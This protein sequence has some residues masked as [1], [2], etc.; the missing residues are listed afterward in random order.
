ML[1]AE[2]LAFRKRGIGGSESAAILGVHPWLSAIEL[3]AQKCGFSDSSDD[4]VRLRCGS[5][6]ESFVRKEYER[7][8]GNAVFYSKARCECLTH[9][10]I[11]EMLANVDGF[12]RL[13]GHDRIVEIKTVSGRGA[14]AWR[15]GPPLYVQV[16][17]QHYME[18]CDVDSADVVALVDMG[19]LKI[20]TLE[21]DPV[22][23]NEK[24]IPAVR[25]FWK[26]VLDQE[27]PPADTSDSA[28]RG[29]MALYPEPNGETLSDPEA[30]M[31]ALEYQ[32]QKEVEAEAKRAS[33]G[34]KNLLLDRMAD[35]SAL[36]LGDGLMLYRQKSG[37]GWTLKVKDTNG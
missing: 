5:F 35:A 29:L 37:R 13:G 18:V 9:P 2:Q 1:T 3:F 30:L 24:L 26:R 36:D 20:W 34:L 31:T 8:T 15:D 22:F 10:Q 16:Q 21:R 17:V 33:K 28:Y 19:D 25:K 27:P 32:A 14:A 4:N 7:E 6:L 11:P 23:A 12:T